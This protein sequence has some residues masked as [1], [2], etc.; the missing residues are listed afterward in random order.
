VW[1]GQFLGIMELGQPALLL[2]DCFKPLNAC[3]RAG[4]GWPADAYSGTV[5]FILGFIPLRRVSSYY[6]GLCLRRVGQKPG[7]DSRLEQW[8]A[9]WCNFAAAMHEYVS[10]GDWTE[11]LGHLR[12][13]RPAFSAVGDTRYWSATAD[14]LSNLLIEQGEFAE[15]LAFCEESVR[16]GHETGDQVAEAWGQ[17]DAGDVLYAKGALEEAE[18]RLRPA[19]EQL[20]LSQDVAN[21]AKAA[22]RIAHCCL[23]QGRLEEAHAIL[24]EESARVREAGSRGYFI[25]NVRTG[26]ATMG[27]LALEQAGSAEK[28]RAFKEA[29][30]ACRELLKHGKADIAALVPAYRMRGTYE[31]LRGRPGKAEK[32]W[33]KSLEHAEKLGARYEGALTHLEIGRRLGDRGYLE[34]AEAAFA[35]M[36][37]AFDLAE[38]QQLLGRAEDVEEVAS[39]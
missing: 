27:L 24:V 11:A 13:A 6:Y 36:G 28:G 35:D 16:F 7:D 3:E 29:Q 8:C 9:A 18:A 17:M 15:A 38:A 22:A 31:W 25:R 19:A 23:K 21:A 26:N 39:P 37:A 30:K 33:Q 1:I 4:L 2:F 20:R 34:Q 5:S 10:S 32:W 12:F 14:Q